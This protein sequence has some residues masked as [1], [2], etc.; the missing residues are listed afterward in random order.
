MDAYLKQML[1]LASSNLRTH[2]AIVPTIA[3]RDAHE[4]APMYESSQISR[5]AK[6][7]SQRTRP[8][9]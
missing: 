7:T 2:Q 8:C 9:C 3:S 6:A 5:D 4:D 1:S